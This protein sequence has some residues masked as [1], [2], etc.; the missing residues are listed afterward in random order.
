MIP[1]CQKSMN[2]ATDMQ[3][4]DELREWCRDMRDL[5]RCGDCPEVT[6]REV[7]VKRVKRVE[8]RNGRLW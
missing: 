7:E 8:D 1:S 6:G 4:T 2:P 3:S 5:R